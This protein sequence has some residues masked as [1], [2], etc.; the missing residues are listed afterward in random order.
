[1]VDEKKKRHNIPFLIIGHSNGLIWETEY[2]TLINL[3][4]LE[5]KYLEIKSPLKTRDL[6]RDQENLFV[7]FWLLYI[8]YILHTSYFK[9]VYESIHLIYW[10]D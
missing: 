2:Y 8:I 9:Q 7:S 5:K 10:T 6:I 3:Y 4:M 1:M